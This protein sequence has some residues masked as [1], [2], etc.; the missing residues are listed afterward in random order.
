MAISAQVERRLE[1]LVSEMR[2]LL[3]GESGSPAGGRFVDLEDQAAEIGD[4]VTR[5]LLSRVL[6]AQADRAAG[7]T[8]ACCP[9]CGRPSAP[10]AEP[11][12]RVV[13]T[14]RG[15]VGWRETKHS[16]RRCRRDFFPSES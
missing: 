5:S 2:Q 8:E 6:Q 10:D 3:Y 14:R 12:P 16:C 11:E 9:Q 15:E 4:A 1:E 7:Q 13:Q